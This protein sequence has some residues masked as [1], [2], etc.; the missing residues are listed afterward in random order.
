MRDW[1]SILVKAGA[2]GLVFGLILQLILSAAPSVLQNDSLSLGVR[3][4]IQIILLLAISSTMIANLSALTEIQ[5]ARRKLKWKFFWALVVS[6]F[7]LVGMVV[8]FYSF[9]NNSS[10]IP[11]DAILGAGAGAFGTALYLTFSV[12]RKGASKP[13]RI[14]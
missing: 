10:T 14:S 13:A 8:P 7:Q 4:T 2:I 3:F 12:K 1:P 11:L 9:M 5:S 6:A